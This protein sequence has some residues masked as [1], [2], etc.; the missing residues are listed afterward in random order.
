MA[1]GFSA[2]PGGMGVADGVGDAAGVGVTGSGVGEFN[3]M[4]I[5]PFDDPSPQEASMRA[6]KKT[7]AAL[8]ECA[9]TLCIPLERCSSCI[10]EFY[11]QTVI[12]HEKRQTLQASRHA[13]RWRVNSPG[14]G[15]CCKTAGFL[16]PIPVA[17]VK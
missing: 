1:I 11:H 5:P 13:G 7:P 8:N 17:Y 9:M 10:Q 6:R 12:C 16:Q 4:G 3:N 15:M 2:V 14:E